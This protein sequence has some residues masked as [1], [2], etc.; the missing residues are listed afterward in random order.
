MPIDPDALRRAKPGRVVGNV[1]V[2]AAPSA[3]EVESDGARLLNAGATDLLGLAADARVREAVQAALRKNGVARAPRS[4]AQLELEE[5]LAKLLGAAAAVVLDDAGAALSCLDAAGAL[6]D[7]NARWLVPGG[8]LVASPEDAERALSLASGAPLLVG[9]VDAHA[10]DLSPLH[11]FAEAAQRAGAPLVVLDPVGLG[12]LG[13]AGLGAVESLGLG[14]QTALQGLFLGHAIPGSGAVFA[15]PAPVVDALRAAG[16]AP[17]VAML[18]ATSRALEL[19]TTE[20]PRRARVFDVAQ[21]LVDGLRGLG[22]DTGP[23]VTPWIPLWMGD[24]ALAEQWLRA[25]ADQ[26][27]ACRALLTGERSRLLVS[28]AATATD[29]QVD[30]ALAAFEKVARKLKPP[31]LDAAW[32]GPVLLARPG[33]FALATPCAPCWREAIP[34]AA[35]PS[36][37]V[38]P[39]PAPATSLRARLFDA[40]E[41]LTWRATNV[42]GTKLGLPGGEAL[43]ALLDRRRRR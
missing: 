5:R 1:R 41:T 35:L 13:P 20:A 8:V 10:G 33:S 21:Q 26:G 17:P 11:R 36:P 42:R 40:V 7:V 16:C 22:L 6:V 25:L 19:A 31:A 3:A 37:A 18:A 43:K 29:A 28:M 15:G 14:D 27:V 34:P 12:V 2:D 39:A 9:A 24:E 23:C 32:R 30:V 4:K 38:E